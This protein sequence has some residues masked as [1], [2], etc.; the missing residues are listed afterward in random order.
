MLDG[1]PWAGAK[2]DR[3]NREKGVER[4]KKAYKSG[5]IN[6]EN[7]NKRGYNKFLLMFYDVTTLYFET[8]NGDELRESGFSKDG[9]HSQPQVVLGTRSLMMLRDK[10]GLKDYER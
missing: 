1:L 10:Y 4:L 3:Y 2:K 9:K 5:S 7:I 6:K 8:D